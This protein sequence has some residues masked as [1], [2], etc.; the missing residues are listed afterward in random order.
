MTAARRRCD[1]ANLITAQLLFLESEDAEKDIH[2]YINSP[3]GSVTSAMSI[4]DAMQYVQ[5]AVA[6]LCLGMAASGGSLLLTAGAPGQ[7]RAAS[8]IDIHAREILRQRDT[9]VAMYA[10]HTGRHPEQVA[11]D[12]DRDNYMT[13]E[14]ALGYGLIDEIIERR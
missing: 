9:L 7:R 11:A 4:Y 10:R 5:P 8:E 12:M 1:S 6:T 3:G 2:L 13:A 14:Q